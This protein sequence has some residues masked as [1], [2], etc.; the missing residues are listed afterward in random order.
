MAGSGVQEGYRTP[1]E[2]ARGALARYNPASILSKNSGDPLSYGDEYG[3]LIYERDGRYHFTEAVVGEEQG[4]VD[5]WQTLDKIPAD[6]RN[7][8]VGDYHTHGG[9]NPIVDGEDFSGLRYGPGSSSGSLRAGSDIVEAR[10]DL[11]TRRANILDPKG[12][13]SYLGTP[14]GRFSVYNPHHGTVFSFSSSS[15]LL[16]PNT[17]IPASAYA[18]H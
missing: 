10:T 6:A 18:W 15:R 16:P 8:V 12:Y 3:G 9:P 4:H 5:P 13:T 11:V 2:A 7:R 14:S 1:W 17:Q